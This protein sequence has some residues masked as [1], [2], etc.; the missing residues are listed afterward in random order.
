VFALELIHRFVPLLTRGD[1]I[2]RDLE[3]SEA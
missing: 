2:P 3:D 1:S